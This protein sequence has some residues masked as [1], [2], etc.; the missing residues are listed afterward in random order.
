MIFWS[1]DEYNRLDEAKSRNDA[2]FLNSLIC[3]QAHRSLF[4]TSATQRLSGL[5]QNSNQAE[6][7]RFFKLREKSAS[8]SFEVEIK[9]ALDDLH[10]SVFSV[11]EESICE[12][13]ISD[14]TIMPL[15]G[16]GNQ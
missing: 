3:P 9:V 8:K 4:T 14:K 13:K 11:I 12:L 5:Q 10:D 16:E 2:L 6:I 7:D 1:E 15:R